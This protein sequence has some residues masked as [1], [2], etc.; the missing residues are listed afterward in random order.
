MSWTHE[1]SE[2]KVER[3]RKVA[4]ETTN[5]LKLG[6]GE[7]G[8]PVL[9]GHCGPSSAGLF[10]RALF[11]WLWWHFL[12]GKTT[13][14]NKREELVLKLS[15]ERKNSLKTA[16]QSWLRP[17]ASPGA[18]VA[19]GNRRDTSVTSDSSGNVSKQK[20]EEETLFFFN[21]WLKLNKKNK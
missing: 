21:I 4:G 16:G 1:F 12:W 19:P 8:L 18:C 7:A 20:H 17:P 2:T 10:G 5:L 11:S 13:C 15:G 14:I 6:S 9:V 3:K